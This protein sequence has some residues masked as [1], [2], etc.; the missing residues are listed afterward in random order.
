MWPQRR[1]LLHLLLRLQPALTELS[2]SHHSHELRNSLVSRSQKSRRPMQHP[3]TDP[4]QM[5]LR[6]PLRL[7]R[8]PLISSLALLE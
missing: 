7:R 8:L 1:P 3:Q 4:R 6:L 5:P 2:K